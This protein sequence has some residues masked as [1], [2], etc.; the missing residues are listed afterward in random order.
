M[1][2]RSMNLFAQRTAQIKR[3]VLFLVHAL[4]GVHLVGSL[5]AWPQSHES[6]AKSAAGGRTEVSDGGRARGRKVLLDAWFNSQKRKNELGEMSYFH[7]KW[8]DK[9]DTGFSVFG[10]LFNDYGVA[11]ETL[12][13]P[14][15]VDKLSS[16]QFYI[17]ASPDIPA[18]NPQPHYVTG[19]DA[20]QV[21]AWVKR[22]G[23][24][25]LM[26][27][28]PANADIEHFDLLA[29]KFGIHFNSVLSHHVV[30]DKFSMG[31]IEVAGGGEVFK[32]PHV[33]FMK[34]TCTIT[35]KGTARPLLV[36]NGDIMMATA[37]YGKGT[38][39][40]VVDPWL[41]NEYVDGHR[42]PAEYDNLNGG[43]ELVEWLM[44]Q[45]PGG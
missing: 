41:Y 26:E 40:A 10:G 45:L 33:L 35:L 31:R 4:L 7:Y 43:R 9:S 1:D 30:D 29:D 23:I 44:R 12:Y 13:E 6:I 20:V 3:R 18:K 39:L 17:I 37:N 28:D 34:D 42:L 24:L 21:A 14:P 2:S 16:A 27:N 22:G 38:V 32:K 25:L 19:E 5:C 11:T 36:D 15:T 8:D